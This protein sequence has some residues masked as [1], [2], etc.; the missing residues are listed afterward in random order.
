MSRLAVIELRSRAWIAVAAVIL[1]VIVVWGAAGC[2]RGGL[3]SDAGSQRGD[4]GAAADPVQDYLQFTVA[5]EE[6]EAPVSAVDLS[7]VVEG[8]RR[9]AGA[10]GTLTPGSPDLQVDL[11]VAAEHVLLSP[12]SPAT[13]AAVREGLLKAADAVERGDG[14][15][16]ALHN[17]AGAID[18]RQ[19]L[20]EQQATVRTFFREAAIAIRARL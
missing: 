3:N 13:S 12:E 16:V 15:H 14:E 18:P 10:L 5:L 11:R 2:G 19:P 7:F 17:V 1:A 8:L 20:L 6:S 9:L 4:I